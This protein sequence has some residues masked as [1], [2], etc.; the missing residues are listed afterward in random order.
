MNLTRYEHTTAPQLCALLDGDRYAFAVMRNILKGMFGEVEKI[1]TDHERLTL[2]YTCPPYPGWVWL[3]QDASEGEMERAW[4]LIAQELPPEAG[5]CVNVS[6]ALA[7]YIVRAGEGRM[8]VHMRLN[9]YGC[10]EAV[11]PE[12]MAQGDVYAVSSEMLDQAAAWAKALSEEENLDLRP[13]QAH[14]QEMAEFIGKKRLFMW[15]TPEGEPAAMCTVS[16]NDGLGYIG[17]VYTPPMHRRHGYAASL[18]YR[19]TR[20]LLRQ[21]KCPALYVNAENTPAIRCYKK[22]GYGPMGT[23]CTVGI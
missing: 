10:R 8:R 19:I 23:V 3:P 9:A 5:Y 15:K 18:M 16:E 22:I 2:C 13:L 7:Q 1:V 14:T 20:I 11:S 21:G 17:H 6:D 4:A 12:R